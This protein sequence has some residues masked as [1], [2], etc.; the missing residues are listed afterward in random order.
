M[1]KSVSYDRSRDYQLK[2]GLGWILGRMGN[3]SESESFDEDTS[4]EF[5]DSDNDKEA[6]V[7]KEGNGWMNGS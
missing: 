2:R 6:C 7:Q 3:D 1:A 4:E 5:L